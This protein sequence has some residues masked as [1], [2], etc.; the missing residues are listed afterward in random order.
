MDDE[1]FEPRELD[2]S[3]LTSRQRKIR[4]YRDKGRD[5]VWIA[6]RTGIRVDQLQKISSVAEEKMRRNALRARR[7]AL[8][9]QE[10][11]SP[12]SRSLMNIA[13]ESGF[14]TDAALHVGRALDHEH[15]TVARL[16]GEV[17]RT[18]LKELFNHAA[19]RILNSVTDI[20]IAKASL[21]DKLV[22]AAVATDKGLILDGQPTEIFSLK[23]MRNLDELMGLMVSEMQR[24]KLSADTQPQ[25]ITY[26]VGPKEHVE[27]VSS[28]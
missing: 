12:E 15:V 7:K 13:N 25:P 8:L 28:E 6:R 27:P 5:W 24:R 26:T 21:R 4:M 11:T 19:Y 16:L 18:E 2:V 22:A 9:T 17:K 14:S 23:E 1:V 20:D 3:I 10:L